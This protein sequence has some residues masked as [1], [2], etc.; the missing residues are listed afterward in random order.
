M[1]SV[2]NYFHIV[3][4]LFSKSN[5]GRSFSNL[6]YIHFSEFFSKYFSFTVYL[7]YIGKL[8]VFKVS[9][10]NIFL[11]FFFFW[12]RGFCV[13]WKQ[14]INNYVSPVS[15]ISNSIICTNAWYPK[16]YSVSQKKV[17]IW[18]DHWVCQ[19]VSQIAKQLR[20]SGNQRQAQRINE[21]LYY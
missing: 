12:C 8:Q 5:F 16:Y 14:Y 18:L 9:V 2:K 7:Y 6:R 13:F 19:S 17:S 21:I 1:Y 3:W 15:Q 10:P 11:F 4:L 20:N